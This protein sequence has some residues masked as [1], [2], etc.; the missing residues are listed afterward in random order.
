MAKQEAKSIEFLRV[1]NPW[2]VGKN[3]SRIVQ[4]YVIQNL[5]APE[6]KRDTKLQ[7]AIKHLAFDVGLAAENGLR[8]RIPS[9]AV[10]RDSLIQTAF[11]LLAPERRIFRD[12]K[13]G[14]AGKHGSFFPIVAGLAAPTGRDDGLGRR[15]RQL[16]DC[17]D[18]GWRDRLH[19]L[20]V[21]TS[22]NDPVTGFATVLLGGTSGELS[23]YT[24][25]HGK[26]K[27]SDFD[28]AC[29]EFVDHLISPQTNAQRISAIRNLAIGSY[30]VST[31]EM[32]AGICSVKDSAP[33]CVFVYGG[34]PPGDSDDPILRATC[35]SF[36]SWVST[37]WH[38]TAQNIIE[39]M[40]AAPTLP[41]ST[42]AEKREQQ[43]K[44]LLGAQLQNR[45]K[46]VDDL[47][48]E[49]SHFYKLKTTGAD[50]VRHVMESKKLK[51]SK[52]ELARRVRSLGTNIG[53]VGPD[54]GT[55]NP[56]L[57]LDTPLLVA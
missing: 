39:R 6:F 52:T 31:I 47:V 32:V 34:L 56:R 19:Q 51:F 25:N 16:M 26:K 20:L 9:D 55:G 44:Q 54:R 23:A 13:K 57:F 22:A 3:V 8:D 17:V 37:S 41:K 24:E 4:V 2:L 14:G 29:A 43:L 5:V 36:Q 18:T 42:V 30:L 15:L 7:Q 10:G 28:R 35:Q 49:L 45:T 48:K 12:R 38:T 46:D 53:F 27:H 40:D 21:P 33:P 1:G 11:G 50:W